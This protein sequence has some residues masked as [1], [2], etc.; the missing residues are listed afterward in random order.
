[1]IES[2]PKEK[3][4]SLSQ[5]IPGLMSRILTSSEES[6]YLQIS[7][8]SV[9]TSFDIAIIEDGAISYISNE[10]ARKRRQDFL[11]HKEF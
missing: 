5:Y 3:A 6:E 11:T 8:D 2:I 1:M 7:S 10:S 4:E 9:F